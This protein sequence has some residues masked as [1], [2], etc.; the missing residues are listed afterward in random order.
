V[1]KQNKQVHNSNKLK[2]SVHKDTLG[3]DLYIHN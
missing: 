3:S 2:P 1:S